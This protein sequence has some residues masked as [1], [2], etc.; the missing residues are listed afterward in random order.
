MF[1]LELS[2]ACS[3]LIAGS[4]YVSS[5]FFLSRQGKRVLQEGNVTKYSPSHLSQVPM[6]V[7][8]IVNFIY[9]RI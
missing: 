1:I 7:G 5:R 3:L 6:S 8:Q 9:I 2:Q 4:F